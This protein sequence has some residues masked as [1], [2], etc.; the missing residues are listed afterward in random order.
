MIHPGIPEIDRK[1]LGDVWDENI[2]NDYRS[3]ELETL[4]DK[5]VLN[6]IN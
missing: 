1:N 6:G 3:K 4:L 5:N 2:L